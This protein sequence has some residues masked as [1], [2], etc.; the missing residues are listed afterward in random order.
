MRYTILFTCLLS[1][2]SV[3]ASASQSSGAGAGKVTLP[4]PTSAINPQ[5]LPPRADIRTA[6]NPQPLPPHDP[7]TVVDRP[8][9][10]T[11]HYIGETEKNTQP[12]V[13]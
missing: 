4:R 13:R 10:T 1:L 7:P 9:Q 6:V 3:A 12:L 5:P 2:A 8:S 11:T